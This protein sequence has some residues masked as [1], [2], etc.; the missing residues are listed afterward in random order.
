[1]PGAMKFRALSALPHLRRNHWAVGDYLLK[2]C[3]RVVLRNTE[4]DSHFAR[5]R[6][7]R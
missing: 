4:K 1:M 3:D 6:C 7:I 5:G 2:K